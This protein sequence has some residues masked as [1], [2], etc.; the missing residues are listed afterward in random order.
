MG[1]AFERGS[2]KLQ[3]DYLALF[4]KFKSELEMQKKKLQGNNAATSR[5]KVSTWLNKIIDERAELERKN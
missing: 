4:E 1:K 2:Q 3:A 5:T